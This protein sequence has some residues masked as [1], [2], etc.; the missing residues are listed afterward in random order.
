MA[1]DKWKRRVHPVLR[2]NALRAL[3]ATSPDLMTS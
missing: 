1:A 3:L 2:Q